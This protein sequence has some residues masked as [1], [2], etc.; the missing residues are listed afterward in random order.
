MYNTTLG[1]H[2]PFH[3]LAEMGGYVLLLGCGHNS[4]S[5]I[6][7][8]ESM[9]E[10]PYIFIPELAGNPD[11]I[12]KLRQLDG[13]VKNIQL[14]EFTGC[15]KAFYRAEEPLRN[16]NAV[17]DYKIGH[18]NAQLMKGMDVLDV[19]VP[20]LKQQGDLLLCSK[21]TC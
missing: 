17:K 16:A 2:S 4:N 21:T 1:R 14:T 13:R 20:I 10:M 15:S 19:M 7:V 9:A 6:H 3:K 5:I 11:G 8:A 18:A 12:V